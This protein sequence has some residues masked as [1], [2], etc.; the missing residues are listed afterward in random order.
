[1]D[2]FPRSLQCGIRIRSS[3]TNNRNENI[4]ERSEARGK[5]NEREEG[6]KKERNT[7]QMSCCHIGLYFSLYSSGNSNKIFPKNSSIVPWWFRPLTF[8]VETPKTHFHVNKRKVWF[9]KMKWMKEFI[10]NGVWR[11]MAAMLNSRILFALIISIYVYFWITHDALHQ[12]FQLLQMWTI[13]KHLVR[14]KFSLKVRKVII[15]YL[16]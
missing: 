8:Q 11:D 15:V 13:F 2:V 3:E 12:Q 6:G 1:M 16:L 4:R 5:R 10:Y 7:V 9:L 14:N